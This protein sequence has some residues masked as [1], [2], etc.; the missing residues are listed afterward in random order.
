MT[1]GDFYDIAEYGNKNWKG[2]FTAREIACHAYDY[3]VSFTISKINITSKLGKPTPIIISLL[4]N[5]DED[6]L[7]DKD[8]EEAKKYA[9]LIRED[10]GL[11]QVIYE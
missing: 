9:N 2:D 5:L 1:Y 11:S 10:L 3:F 4:E 8:N 6:I 7:C